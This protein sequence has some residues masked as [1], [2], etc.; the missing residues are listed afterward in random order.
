[1]KIFG[2]GMNYLQHTNELDGEAY[3]P[4][5]PVVFLKADSSLLGN[6]KPFFVPDDMGR[7]DYEA[8][9]IVR[10]GRLGK[11]IAEQFALRYVDAVSVGIDFTARQMQQ[12][13]RQAG[14]PWEICKGFDGAATIGSWQSV[15]RYGGIE[16][17][18]FRLDINQETRQQGKAQD[19]LFSVSQ[20]IAY[21]SRFFTL[22]TGDII[23]TG[24]PVGV[25]EVH[26]N[27]HF[28]GY[29]EGE[30]VLDFHA[31]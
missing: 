27:D 15:E 20:I 19:M 9:L 4:K 30:K 17:L 3:R 11:G 2:I 28:E 1:M 5:E 26:I 31:K 22:K 29:L 23:F 6:G 12:R 8:E 21:I 25:G 13:L 24:T 18:S 10:I 14:L 16:S 7:I